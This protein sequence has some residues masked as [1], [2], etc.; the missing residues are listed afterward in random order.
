MQV[1]ACV[2]ICVYV[3]VCTGMCVYV[4]VC[5]SGEGMYTWVHMYGCMCVCENVCICI[6]VRTCMGMYVRVVFTC[7]S[8]I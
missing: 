6:C 1:N 7:V 5:V 4:C 3:K 8:M 2:S